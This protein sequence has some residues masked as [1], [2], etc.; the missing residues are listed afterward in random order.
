MALDPQMKLGMQQP[1]FVSAYL[2]EIELPDYTIRLLDGSGEVHWGQKSFFGSDP[3]FGA[4]QAIDPIQEQV[5]TEAP[6]MRMKFLPQSTFS[7]ANI[8]GADKQGSPVSIW[9]AV[10]HPETGAV[11]GEP[12]LVFSGELDAAEA[13]I[14]Q[15]ET[16]VTFDIG[17]VWER[18]F[19]NQE[20]KRLN[21]AN[22]QR[23]WA[24]RATQERGFEFVVA[25]Q[26]NEPWGYD[27]PRPALVADVIGGQPASGGGSAGGGIGNGGGGSIGNG[28]GGFGGG[29]V[30]DMIIRNLV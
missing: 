24:E 19:Q 23:V 18:L 10:V 29:S 21:N 20:G 6:L 14:E 27:Q 7:M 30:M 25:I 3:T 5:G 15:S 16:T 2:M 1:Y 26:R 4:I 17:S 8:T 9:W 12:Y 28:G 13:D 22:H 11:I